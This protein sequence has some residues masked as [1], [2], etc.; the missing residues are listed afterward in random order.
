MLLVLCWVLLAACTVRNAPPPIEFRDNTAPALLGDPRTVDPCTLVDPVTITGF[1]AVANAGT[2]SLDY[3]LLHVKPDDRTLLQ[4]TVGEL[5]AF[6]PNDGDPVVRDGSLRIAKNAPVPG[7][8]SRQVLFD[9]G[10]AMQISADLLTGDP[11]AGLCKLAD[12]GA[13]AVAVALQRHEGGHRVTPPN[14]LALVNPCGVLDTGFV[15]QVPG[16]ENTQPRSSPS[17]HQCAWGEQS[18]DSP[19]VQL[20]HTAGQPPRLLHGAAV[21]EQ[22][23]NRRTVISVVGG[24]PSV[25]L[26][27]AETGHIPFGDPGQV[28]VAQLVVALPG[29]DGTEACEYARG[30]ARL[31]WPKL[32]PANP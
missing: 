14:S 19:R 6:T 32:P 20:V 8:C 13:H 3:C 24:D 30:L 11:S 9:D 21:E 2:V 28:E 18:A 5:V 27:S 1:G 17:G 22:I 7:H 26:C 23:A 31:A 15:R 16:L 12:S 10:L 25:P 29:S 4:L